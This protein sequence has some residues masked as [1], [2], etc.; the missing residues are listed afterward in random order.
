MGEKTQL[1]FK[2]SEKTKQMFDLA[3]LLSGKD[4]DVVFEALAKEFAAKV[5]KEC[6]AELCE[7]P[8]K[9]DF[10]EP[11]AV[12]K[13]PIWATRRKGQIGSQIVKAFLLCERDGVAERISMRE[14]FLKNNPDRDPWSFDNNFASMCTEKGN[15]Q[16]LFFTLSGSEV[17]VAECVKTVLYQYKDQFLN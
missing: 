14:T 1:S 17:R 12:G 2:V 11:K 9:A 15:S 16:G 5:L 10:V 13:I 3:I 7:P 8:V 4:Q 6:N